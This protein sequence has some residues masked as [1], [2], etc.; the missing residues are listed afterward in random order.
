[1]RGAAAPTRPA[2]LLL[3]QICTRNRPRHQH[4]QLATARSA[5]RALARQKSPPAARRSAQAFP[6]HRHLKH[7]TAGAS[8]CAIYSVPHT[9]T[10]WCTTRLCAAHEHGSAARSL[11]SD[12][13]PCVRVER[14]ILEHGQAHV[15][16]D[17]WAVGRAK[18]LPHAARMPRASTAFTPSTTHGGQPRSRGAPVATTMASSVRCSASISC[19]SLAI[20][21][22]RWARGHGVFAIR[23][24]TEGVTGGPPLQ[25]PDRHSHQT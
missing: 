19:S 8:V 2:A 21:C 16:R 6:A 22:S 9:E 23:S 12:R 24:P 15:G 10:G 1:V 11:S 7:N 5:F 20:W 13:R 18:P 4:H 14:G 3:F 25:A 17:A